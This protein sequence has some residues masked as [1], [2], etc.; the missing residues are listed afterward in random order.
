M[1]QGKILP[2]KPAL[3]EA[4]ASL[5]EEVT[6]K[7]SEGEPEEMDAQTSTTPDTTWGAPEDGIGGEGEKGL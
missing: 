6:A 4:S 7:V 1:P 3:T 5:N 2:V